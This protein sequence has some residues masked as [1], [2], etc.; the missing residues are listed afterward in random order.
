[1]PKQDIA[2]SREPKKVP[3]KHPLWRLGAYL[4]TFLYAAI[5]SASPHLFPVWILV[6]AGVVVFSLF[7][8][9]TVLHVRDL[10]GWNKLD[11]YVQRYPW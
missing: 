1:M 5:L 7:I 9:A 8:M 3:T 10:G 4:T 2:K 6:V 11:S